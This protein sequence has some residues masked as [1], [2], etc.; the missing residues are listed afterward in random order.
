MKSTVAEIERLVADVAQ[1]ATR[2]GLSVRGV[3]YKGSP[4]NGSAHSVNFYYGT[5]VTVIKAGSLS[6]MAGKLEA[7]HQMNLIAR[8]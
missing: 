2:P 7:M 1:G 6:E 8:Y 4:F 5:A 3:F